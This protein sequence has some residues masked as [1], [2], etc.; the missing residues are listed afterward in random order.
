MRARL[1]FEELCS[2]GLDADY[3]GD[4]VDGVVGEVRG[5]AGAV[6][7]EL[8]PDD[9][10]A[11]DGFVFHLEWRLANEQLVRQDAASPADPSRD[12]H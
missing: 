5:P 4:E 10:G 11:R 1:S 9:H 8:R 12:G 3:L 6:G 2:A 7:W